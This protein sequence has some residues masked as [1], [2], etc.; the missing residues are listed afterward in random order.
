M[1]KLLY[2]KGNDKMKRQLM[3]QEK[4]FANHISDWGLISNILKV[5]LQHN[6][7]KPN[8]PNSIQITQKT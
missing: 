4:I 3:E 5:V 7:K 8:N 1:K 6:S 2:S